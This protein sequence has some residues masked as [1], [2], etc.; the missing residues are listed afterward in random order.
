[1]KK[2]FIC[3]KNCLETA[4]IPYLDGLPFTSSNNLIFEKCSNCNFTRNISFDKKGVANFYSENHS[5]YVGSAQFLETEYANRFKYDEYLRFIGKYF[6]VGSWIDLGCGEGSLLRYSID[7]K[8]FPGEVELAGIDYGANR[9][10]DIENYPQ[11]NYFDQ[12]SMGLSIPKPYDLY[13]MFHVLEHIEDPV[14]YLKII[15]K[16]SRT[17]SILILEVPDSESYHAYFNE[18]YW[19]TIFEHI[20]H[21]SLDSLIRLGRSAG[22]KCIEV[23]RYT[24]KAVGIEYPALLMAFSWS[25][26][27]KSNLNLEEKIVLDARKIALQLIS[28]SKKRRICL[29]GYSKFAK[30]IA[31]FLPAPIPL[32]DSFCVGKYENNKHI[33]F[34]DSPPSMHNYDL[35]VSSSITGFDSVKSAALA[36]GWNEGSIFSIL[37]L[38]PS[39][40]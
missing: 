21:F 24:G 35:I 37:N 26:L 17:G 15:H 14:Q 36:F 10:T 29:W 34:L 12:K 7:K 16:S 18:A 5:G 39:D 1:M 4:T 6:N 31:T 23:K 32:Y 2:C 22:W 38:S 20:N 11:I 40:T 33:N 25:N 28:L 13:T 30:Y 9:L 8:I 19:Y 27:P 3:Q